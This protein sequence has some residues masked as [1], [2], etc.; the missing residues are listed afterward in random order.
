MDSVLRIVGTISTSKARE[1]N[2]P[3]S[4]LWNLVPTCLAFCRSTGEFGGVRS[5]GPG[6]FFDELVRGQGEHVPLKRG[7]GEQALEVGFHF[8]FPDG[9]RQAEV[10]QP[11]VFSADAGGLYC[12]PEHGPLFRF[13][14]VKSHLA[15]P[16]NFPFAGAPGDE[17]GTELPRKASCPVRHAKGPPVPAYA[18]TG[19]P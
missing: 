11:Q 15:P 7:Q 14:W 17:G 18:S 3:M 5:P 19:S 13:I 6:Y 12:C 10:M 16:A 1:G 2:G 4:A 8:V 9:A